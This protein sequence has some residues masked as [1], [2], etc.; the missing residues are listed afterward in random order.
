MKH[1]LH[2]ILIYASLAEFN[3]QNMHDIL[4]TVEPIESTMIE[5]GADD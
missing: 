1:P 5:V 4:V 2:D 3:A